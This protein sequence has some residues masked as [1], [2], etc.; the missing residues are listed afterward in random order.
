MLRVINRIFTSGTQSECTR[1]GNICICMYVCTRESGHCVTEG[2]SEEEQK[3]L[4]GS[5]KVC[6]YV[7]YVDES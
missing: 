4:C 5:V 6:K 1:Y 2:Q 7:K 3:C